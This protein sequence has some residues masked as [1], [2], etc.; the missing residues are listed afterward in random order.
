VYRKL[1][2]ND[3]RVVID[4]N[5][6]FDRSWVKDEDRK[7]V[8]SIS[9]ETAFD[10]TRATD[11][12]RHFVRHAKNV[13][14]F[15]INYEPNPSFSFEQLQ[16]LL[17]ILHENRIHF[18]VISENVMYHSNTP[19][20]FISTI[21]FINTLRDSQSTQTTKGSIPMKIK[22]I[23]TDQTTKE[24]TISD[25]EGHLAKKIVEARESNPFSLQ[26]VIGMDL[27]ANKEANNILM[28]PVRQ[29][30][31]YDDR[32]IE[33]AIRFVKDNPKTKK[34]GTAFVNMVIID[35][36]N[37]GCTPKQLDQLGRATVAAG[38]KLFV[39]LSPTSGF[40]CTTMADVDQVVAIK[41][42]K[43]KNTK[44]SIPMQKSSMKTLVSQAAIRSG[45]EIC[46]TQLLN[47]IADTN[48][49]YKRILSN[50]VMKG[51]L[52]NVVS[53]SLEQVG[54]MAGIE[55]DLYQS[56]I[57]QIKIK[58]ISS[59][60]LGSLEFGQ[61]LIEKLTTGVRQYLPTFTLEEKTVAVEKK[62]AVA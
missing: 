4:T 14:L 54:E 24:S 43:N 33:W 3:F 47:L 25:F 45:A 52:L 21:S 19:D 49:T 58:G 7:S 44:G 51:L 6:T 50:K 29:S 11:T 59:A 42:A 32:D 9:G 18:M 37:A 27:T 48:P 40:T 16:A 34:S 10:G 41:L 23:E 62:A 26:L 2:P 8:I 15:I 5:N 61:T 13:N 1:S 22:D 35:Y 36:D 20:D 56:L 57:D 53:T 46:Y 12:V 17:T 31:L 28:S 39:R 60:A 30:V 55:N 38:A